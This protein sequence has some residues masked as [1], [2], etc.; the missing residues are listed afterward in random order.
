MPMTK[1]KKKK[2]PPV[3]QPDQGEHLLPFRPGPADLAGQAA[4]GEEVGQGPADDRRDPGGQG[5]DQAAHGE[6]GRGQPLGGELEADVPDGQGHPGRGHA[7]ERVDH[8]E[9]GRGQPG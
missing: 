8:D 4:P 5:A 6:V 1:A 7:H 2:N 3:V 9:Q